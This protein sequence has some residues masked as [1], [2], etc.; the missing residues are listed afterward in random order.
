VDID[1]TRAPINGRVET[2]RFV[3]ERSEQ[4]LQASD[5]HFSGPLRLK[6]VVGD[7]GGGDNEQALDA[8]CRRDGRF[9]NGRADTR[10]AD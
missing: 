10:D 6:V 2:E 5:L 9:F 8:W 3:L 1:L 4:D 7:N